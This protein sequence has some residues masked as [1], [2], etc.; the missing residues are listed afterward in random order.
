MRVPTNTPGPINPGQ[1]IMG[2]PI[3]IFHGQKCG[4]VMFLWIARIQIQA[5]QPK[6]PP[7]SPIPNHHRRVLPG[8]DEELRP[9]PEPSKRYLGQHYLFTPGDIPVP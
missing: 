4:E 8:Q 9:D 3:R 7:Q 5:R 1:G 2:A 6:L